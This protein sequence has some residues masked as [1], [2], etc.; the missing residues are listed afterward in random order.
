L[1]GFKFP[2][3]K[4]NKGDSIEMAL[5]CPQI[6]PIALQSFLPHQFDHSKAQSLISKTYLP[7]ATNH[8][9]KQNPS[10]KCRKFRVSRSKQGFKKM[11][12]H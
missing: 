5:P 12:Q 4:G 1:V 11:Q 9:T 3:S 6:S 7:H 8:H 2:N 10:T